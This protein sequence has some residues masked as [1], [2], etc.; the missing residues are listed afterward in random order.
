MRNAG[1]DEPDL[2]RQ[3]AL[4]DLKVIS[5]APIR[6]SACCGVTVSSTSSSSVNSW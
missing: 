6:R 4:R 2:R 5:L 3:L 1:V